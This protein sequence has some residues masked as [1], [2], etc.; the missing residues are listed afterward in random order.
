MLSLL[1]VAL[2]MAFKDSF[3]VL[4]TVAEARGRDHL[5]GLFDAAED[6]AVFFTTIYGAGTAIKYGWNAHAV[7]TLAVMMVVSYFGTRYWTRV[8]RRIKESHAQ[9]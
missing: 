2:A 1:W 5:A 3:G 8:S 6:A 7:E 9:S 4:M